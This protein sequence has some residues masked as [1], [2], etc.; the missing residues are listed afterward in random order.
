MV[1]ASMTSISSTSILSQS[2]NEWRRSGRTRKRE[3]ASMLFDASGAS[4][5]A[6]ARIA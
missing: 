3:T 6:R 2:A 1:A 5:R 4:A